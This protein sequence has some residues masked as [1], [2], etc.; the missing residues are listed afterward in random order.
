MT[1]AKQIFNLFFLIPFSKMQKST[2]NTTSDCHV[3]PKGKADLCCQIVVKMLKSSIKII[4]FLLRWRRGIS[5]GTK[6]KHKINEML[7]SG[8]R[9]NLTGL[10]FKGFILALTSHVEFCLQVVQFLMH[11]SINDFHNFIHAIWQSG[12]PLLIT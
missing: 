11:Q 9:V 1:V 2:K 3:L 8:S 4:C 7:Y 6:I 12:I 5:Q 10:Y